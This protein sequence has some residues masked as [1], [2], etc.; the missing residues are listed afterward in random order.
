[1]YQFEKRQQQNVFATVP[2]P[3]ATGRREWWE[4]EAASLVSLVNPKTAD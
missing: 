3:I 1:M 4:D 2:T